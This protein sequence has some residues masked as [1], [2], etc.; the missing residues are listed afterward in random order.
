VRGAL[1]QSTLYEARSGALVLATG[2]L[3]GVY[4]HSPL[5]GASPDPPRSPD[6]R[7]V[8]MTR[9]LLAHVLRVRR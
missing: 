5:P 2:T 3:G 4:A 1:A 7:V 9:N 6:P 8:A